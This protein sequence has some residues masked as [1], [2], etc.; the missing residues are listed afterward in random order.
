MGDKGCIKLFS[1]IGTDLLCYIIPRK[2]SRGIKLLLD[3]AVNPFPCIEQV[4][5]LMNQKDN[6]LI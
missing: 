5:I 4:D 6:F 3:G 1:L 2:Y